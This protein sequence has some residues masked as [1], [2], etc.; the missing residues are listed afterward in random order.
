MAKNN[1][2]AEQ[3]NALKLSLRGLPNKRL[4]EDTQTIGGILSLLEEQFAGYPN[5]NANRIRRVL[6]YLVQYDDDAGG[7][8]RDLQAFVNPSIRFEFEGNTRAVKRAEEEVSL[9][10]RRMYKGGLKQLIDNQVREVYITGVSSIEWIPEGSKNGVGC[11]QVVKAENIR[12]ERNEETQGF[13]YKQIG[14]S[15][16]EIELHPITY[17]YIPIDT[18]GE[19]PYGLPV[20]I[21]S[22]ASLNRKSNLIEG[23][24]RIINAMRTLALFTAKVTRFE[25]QDFGLNNKSDPEFAQK[26]KEAYNAI[27]DLIAACAENGLYVHPDNVEMGATPV[28]PSITGVNDIH[29]DNQKAVWNGLGTLPFLRGDMS[30][31]YA[32]ARVVMPVILSLAQNVQETIKTQI[33]HGINLHLQLRGIAAFCH[34]G[35]GELDNPFEMDEQEAQVKKAE[36]DE[37]ML[38]MVGDAWLPKLTSRWDLSIEEVIEARKLVEQKRQEQLDKESQEQDEEAGEEE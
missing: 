11:A 31:N 7:T 20:A 2:I 4:S 19:S 36:V 27:A 12:I 8:L 32:L 1:L 10:Q 25:P 15:A 38:A 37:K 22:L 29:K 30:A 13:T 6:R 9:W 14:V 26:S 28:R 17:Q 16:K 5:D 23:T 21:S 35:F 3:A 34:V 24:D 33:E 18:D